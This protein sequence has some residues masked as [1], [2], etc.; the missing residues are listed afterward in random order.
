MR[1]L[2]IGLQA[3]AA[4][5]LVAAL[6]FGAAYAL[7]PS[8]VRQR[9]GLTPELDVPYVA[10]RRAMV[11][12]MLDMAQVGPEDYVIDLGTGDGRILLAAAQDR[13][14]SGMG[15]D[16]DPA[17]IRSA[18]AEAKRQGLSDRVT[19]REQDLFDTPLQDADVV[20]MF[21]LP[22]VNLRLRPRLLDELKPGTRVVSHRFDMGEWEADETR[23]TSG[24]PAYLWIVP[25][26]V[27]GQ[28][29]L[30]LE[31]RSIALELEQEFQQVRGTA[32]VDGEE[33]P[34]TAELRGDLLRFTLIVD[35]KAVRFGGIVSGEGIVSDDAAGWSA[36]RVS[37]K[38]R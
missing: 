33:Q 36:T 5:A 26:R 29:R 12:T 3:L 15:V 19:F 16:L 8:A 2:R 28:W 10:T 22:E 9:L 4:F 21:L 34:V 24:Y 14:A 27:E 30:A 25:A 11:A 13:G 35:G 31:G 6:F 23:K 18:R 17:L 32:L 38:A 20:T 1:V 37:T 7:D